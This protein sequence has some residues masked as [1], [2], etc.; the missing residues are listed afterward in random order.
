MQM[1]SS[2]MKIHAMLMGLF[3]GFFLVGWQVRV[4]CCWTSSSTTTESYVVDAKVPL[5]FRTS[6]ASLLFS[7][8]PWYFSSIRSRQA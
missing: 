1:T 6:N 2:T 8:L 5:R 3:Y 4:A 7:L